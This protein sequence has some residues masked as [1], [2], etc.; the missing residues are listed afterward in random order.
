[1]SPA[2]PGDRLEA[3][4][5]R[6]LERLNLRAVEVEPIGQ[7]HNGN[8]SCHR[9]HLDDGQ[10][11]KARMVPSADDA[12][13]IETLSGHLPAGSFA[14]ILGRCRRALLVEWIPGRPIES[15]DHTSAFMAGCGALLAT[16]HRVKPPG[17]ASWRHPTA[18]QPA[19]ERL[20]QDLRRV[21][22]LGGLSQSAAAGL[23]ADAGR[24][25]P[26]DIQIGLVHWDLCQA[27]VIVGP[28]GGPKVIDQ[29]TL[30]VGPCDGDLARTWYR[31]SLPSD[32]FGAFLSGYRVHREATTFEAQFW[33]W[34]VTALVDSA[35][36][37]LRMGSGEARVPLSM[38]A[39]AAARGVESLGNPED[40]R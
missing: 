37:R 31:W 11:V 12:R 22:E 9:L 30:Y 15:A 13:R 25:A 29:D 35:L 19:R 32:R 4:V 7:F 1:M 33:Y 34:A 28:D 17:S 3:D 40:W 2:L 26:E 24:Y 8:R 18:E 23:A 39:Q 16:V 21:V 10:S 14:R 5:V 20:S 38:L 36:W 27:N 6:L